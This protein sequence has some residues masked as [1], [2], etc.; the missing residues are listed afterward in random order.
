MAAC[1]LPLV[2]SYYS[3]S[4]SNA[5]I[6]DGRSSLRSGV[7]LS[8]QMQ[9]T[10]NKDATSF[11]VNGVRAERNRDGS[12]GAE[13]LADLLGDG[14]FVIVS[15]TKLEYT[16]ADATIAFEHSFGLTPDPE[17]DLA[18]RRL[19]QWVEAELNTKESGISKSAAPD[20]ASFDRVLASAPN[21][22]ALKYAETGVERPLLSP[23]L[24]FSLSSSCR[25]D[26]RSRQVLLLP[27]QCIAP[28][29]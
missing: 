28:I 25:F 22:D 19:L 27:L 2:L 16:T 6:E 23:P 11:T 9:I 14:S 7:Y 24:P 20:Y 29:L 18:N 15:P 17:T 13:R 26:H 10:I 4:S 5:L 1:L 12:F 3:F 8:D 21:P